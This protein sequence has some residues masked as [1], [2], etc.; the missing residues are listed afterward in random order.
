MKLFRDQ[1]ACFSYIRCVHS[2]NIVG[3]FHKDNHKKYAAKE[4]RVRYVYK[5]STIKINK[6]KGIQLQTDTTLHKGGRNISIVNLQ[7]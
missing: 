7:L 4:T 3:S 2:C 1:L 6:N 5:V